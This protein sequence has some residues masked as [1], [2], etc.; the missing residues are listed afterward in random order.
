V[1][2]KKSRFRS[3]V[4]VFRDTVRILGRSSRKIFII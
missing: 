1:E 4:T 3:L 2:T